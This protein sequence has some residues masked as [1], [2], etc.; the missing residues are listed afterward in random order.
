MHVVDMK[1]DET[2]FRRPC[3]RD[4]HEE[5]TDEQGEDR[6]GDHIAQLPERIRRARG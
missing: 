6:S 5:D 1:N 3:S 2:I 4:A